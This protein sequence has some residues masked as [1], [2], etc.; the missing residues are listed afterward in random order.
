MNDRLDDLLFEAPRSLVRAWL[1][2]AVAALGLSAFFALALVA[3]RTPYIGA[4]LPHGAFARALVLHVDLATLVWFMSSA[5]ALWALRLPVR[6]E[7]MVRVAYAISFAGAIAM[8]IAGLAAPGQAV[9]SNYVPMVDHPLYLG[10]LVWFALGV[11]VSAFAALRLRAAGDAQALEWAKLPLAM[12]G[13]SLLLAST[14]PA[15][16]ASAAVLESAVWGAGHLLQFTY[17]LLLM[18]C[19][20]LLAGT[21]GV[22]EI[23]AS[24]K[25]GLFVLGAAPVLATPLMHWIYRED[26]HG[27]WL[28]YSQLMSWATWPAPLLLGCLLLARLWRDRDGQVTPERLALIGSVTLFAVGCLAGASIRADTTLVPAHYHGTIGAVTAALMALAYRMLPDLGAK[29]VVQSHARLQLTVYVLGL[30]VVICG[31]AWSGVLGA[32]RKSS[33]AAGGASVTATLAASLI[34]LGGA[35]S[36]GAVLAFVWMCLHSLLGG[37]RRDFASRSRD[38]VRRRTITATTAAVVALGAVIAWWP[39]SESWR[40]WFGIQN[41]E[42][43]ARADHV[44]QKR[45]AEIKARFDQ[46]VLMLHAKQYEHAITAFHRVLELEPQLP[47]AH[48]N[49]GFALIGERRFDAARDFFHSATELRRDQ[50]NA[51]YGLA[52]ALKGLDDLPGAVGAMRTYLHRSTEEDPFRAKAQTTLREWETVLSPRAKHQALAPR[53]Q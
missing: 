51:Y 52:V 28:A 17:V 37:F 13:L 5:C 36:V 24:L 23:P 41:A 34:G 33:F 8:L 10:G 25:R 26:S 12:A 29:A 1:L 50:V 6:R 44:A 18:Y 30:L 27:L 43:K 4:W 22:A 39:D 31:L 11:L 16:H 20:S 47:E 46:G 9:L 53:P 48:V 14:N 3:A 7:S 38:D 45:D 40:G 32:P 42:A 35:A 21:L 15:G 2:L 19:W 49:M